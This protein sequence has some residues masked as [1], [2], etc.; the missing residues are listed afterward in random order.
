MNRVNAFLPPIARVLLSSLFVWAGF[1]KLMHPAEAAQYFADN[2]VPAPGLAA[3]IV[4]AIELLGGLAVFVG[5]KTKWAAGILA[6]WTLIT[7][8]AVH[9]VVAIGS[10]DAA[11]VNDNM[12]HF[13]K[14]LVIAGGL[15]YVVA[16]GA[17][18]LSLDD[19]TRA[20]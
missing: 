7:A 14:N 2:G 11:V 17:G 1:A 4:I 10:V 20:D 8:F 5:F 15:L 18:T 9:F 3:W 19:G 6:I 12:I 13:Y 16:F